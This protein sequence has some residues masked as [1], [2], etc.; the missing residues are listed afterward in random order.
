MESKSF[1]PQTIDEED[2]LFDSLEKTFQNV[3]SEL[4][5][6]TTLDNFRLE[7][8]KLY[9]TLRE[10]HEANRAL[11]QK[12]TEL[13]MEIIENSKKI[14]A[15]LAAGQ[16]DQN[17]IIKLR[18][19]FNEA[20]KLIEGY[21]NKEENNKNVIETLKQEI[22]ELQEKTQEFQKLKDEK[23]RKENA[24]IT[25]LQRQIQAIYK[26]VTKDDPVTLQNQIRVGKNET[27]EYQQN[28]KEL[29]KE[30]DKIMNEISQLSK[31]AQDIHAESISTIQSIRAAENDIVDK[32]V[33]VNDL[34]ENIQ[35][36]QEKLANITKKE[37]ED[38]AITKSVLQTDTIK[39]KKL[40][41]NGLVTLQKIKKQQSEIQKKIDKKDEI[42]S[43]TN[44]PPSE[45]KKIQQLDKERIK[46]EMELKDIQEQRQSIRDEI[47][48]AKQRLKQLE[49]QKKQINTQKHADNL[50]KLSLEVQRQQEENE[51]SKINKLIQQKEEQ[52]LFEQQ[53]IE[54]VQTDFTEIKI[55][56][57]RDNKYISALKND[58]DKSK[59]ETVE[60]LYQ[61]SQEI[62][63]IKDLNDEKQKLDE[64][65]VKI[66][67][68]THIYETKIKEETIDSQVIQRKK[69]TANKEKTSLE[70]ESIY[71]DRNIE[72][73]KKEVDY[74]DD[75]ILSIH[76]QVKEA[77][78]QVKRLQKQVKQMKLDYEE[79]KRNIQNVEIEISEKDLLLAAAKHENTTIKESC[80][81]FQKE[82][83]KV[84]NQIFSNKNKSEALRE[85]IKSIQGTFNSSASKYD[86]KM[87][88]IETLK[89][90]LNQKLDRRE[91]LMRKQIK[92]QILQKENKRLEKSISFER[93]KVA[94]LE[95]ELENPEQIDI[96]EIYAVSDPELYSMLKLKREL[97]ST[98]QETSHRAR[99]L[100]C[101]LEEEN[102]KKEKLQAKLRPMSNE[103]YTQEIANLNKIIKQKQAALNRITNDANE[104]KKRSDSAMSHVNDAKDELKETMLSIYETRL[105]DISYEPKPPSDDYSLSA[106]SP[107]IPRIKFGNPR[108]SKPLGSARIIPPLIKKTPITNDPCLHSSR[109]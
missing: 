80:N 30:V 60:S 44:I 102:A 5:N 74:H 39:W 36:Q 84:V 4:V 66:K 22:I 56:Q 43:R 37:S 82:K 94:L 85:Q 17:T 81:E 42:L 35:Q 107:R 40:Y 65:R 23:D 61:L 73:M 104:K 31:D 92:H 11:I 6:D 109:I 3:I 100:K 19:E 69:I 96:E 33:I 14:Q 67:E 13:N 47:S 71:L 28:V 108:M 41:Q 8:E 70:T 75:Q 50:E 52:F 105:K 53:K 89:M 95:E 79:M 103:Q 24:Q 18:K 7:Y 51:V 63:R 26:T 46:Y 9:A 21:S 64:R 29:R 48:Q 38:D 45:E 58:I 27:K 97:T 87:K 16:S 90:E 106:K 25:D 59:K 88:E 12:V 72:D 99:R 32:N 78:E 86:S 15:A 76:C 91:Q 57:D 101:L 49:N 54:N 10:S 77:D 2:K 1:S 98:I 55:V 62:R 68:L 20:W 83:S 34:K 93:Q